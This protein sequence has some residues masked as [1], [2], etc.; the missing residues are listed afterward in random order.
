M[1]THPSLPFFP[2]PHTFPLLLE[3]SR[4]LRSPCSQNCPYANRPFN[5]IYP[6]IEHR[7]LFLPS[8]FSYATENTE[9]ALR[10]FTFFFSLLSRGPDYR[11]STSSQEGRVLSSYFSFPLELAPF[12]LLPAARSFPLPPHD[13][14]CTLFPF[15]TLFSPSTP[16][17][18]ISF[19]FC[20]LLL[21]FLVPF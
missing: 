20:F 15:Q 3:F 21:D 7:F 12:F 4:P 17:D 1:T 9:E 6:K 11:I 18:S 14:K 5:A 8:F 13:A 10:C 16:S 2:F 19:F